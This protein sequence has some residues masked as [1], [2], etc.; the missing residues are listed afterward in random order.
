VLRLVIEV[1]PSGKVRVEVH[2][3]DAETEVNIAASPDEVARS[4]TQAFS[5]LPV[6]YVNVEPFSFDRL[7]LCTIGT[8]PDRIAA[9][10]YTPGPAGDV[11]G[12]GWICASCRGFIPRD[13]VLPQQAPEHFYGSEDPSEKDHPSGQ[14]E[15]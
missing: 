8:V 13:D 3:G 14:V 12:G 6:G 7:C 2:T 9:G 15:G 4:M 1:D 5:P 11:N 10:Q